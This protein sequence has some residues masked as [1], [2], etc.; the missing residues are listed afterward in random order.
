VDYGFSDVWGSVLCLDGWW[1]FW[2]VGKEG[3]IGMISILFG[4]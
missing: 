1:I 3:S 4:M 2:L